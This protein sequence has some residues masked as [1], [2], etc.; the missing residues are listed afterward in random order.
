MA[1]WGEGFLKKKLVIIIKSANRRVEWQNNNINNNRLKGRKKKIEQ[2]KSKNAN[3]ALLPPK[4]RT[5]QIN[6]EG[7]GE[8]TEE[9][10]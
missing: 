8:N 4:S 5:K 2:S 1:E 3:R 6:T 10:R 9:R 7:G